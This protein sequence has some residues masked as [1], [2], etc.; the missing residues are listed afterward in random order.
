MVTR[1][2]ILGSLAT[3]S[4]GKLFFQTPI[5]TAA[6]SPNHKIRV[7]AL[8]VGDYTFWGIWA[9]ILSKKGEFGGGLLDMEISHCWDVN[10]QKAQTFASKYHCEVV[11]KYDGMLGKVDAIAFGGIYEVPWQHLLAR[12]YVEAGVPT[13]L[14]RPFSYRMRDI[15]FILDLAAKRNTPLMA[16]SVQE[17]Y[18]Q[19]SYLQKRL[20]QLGIIKS[21]QGFC[22]SD[23][24]PAHFHIP[25]FILR[26]VGYDVDKVSLITDDA[27]KAS[28]L[29]ET[30]LFKKQKGQP[31]FLASLH[32][33]TESHYL[34][35]NVIAERGNQIITV[36]RSPNKKETLYHYFAPQLVDMQRTFRGE[37][38]Q[39]F[40]IIRKKTQIFLAGYYSHLERGGQLTGL[41]DV[42]L[43]WSPDYFKS[44]WIDEGIFQ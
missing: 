25:W 35:V 16:T 38:F 1:R 42:P 17:H 3:A 23:E 40:D 36:D 31:P 12:P 9:D 27:R 39:S 22:R 26:T 11:E 18:Y 34:Y 30:I 6:V 37:S 32:G 28:F 41:D 2:S 29:Q 19:A 14:S 8:N 43:D 24:Y 10:L 5:T 21:I 13:Y 15:D 44:G 7:G 20:D 33:L 4:L